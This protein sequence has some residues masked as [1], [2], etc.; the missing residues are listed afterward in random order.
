MKR[1]ADEVTG[2]DDR[3]G[4][5]VSTRPPV[6]W[7]LFACML[8]VVN[9]SMSAMVRPKW[10]EAKPYINGETTE[11]GSFR[12]VRNPATGAI[13]GTVQLAEGEHVDAAVEAA[14]AAFPGWR[15]RTPAERGR[16]LLDACH[17]VERELGELAATI[18][19]EVGK[20]RHEAF[21][22]ISG[23]LA[24]LRTFVA[25]V[26]EAD[27]NEDQTGKPGTGG[28]VR[29]IVRRVPVGPVAVIGPWN[30]P[31]FLTFNGVAPSLATGCTVVVK[32]PVEAPLALTAMLRILADR[33][34]P[35]V[36]NVVP[37]RGGV[38]GQRLA[39]HPRIRAIMFT[40]STEVG[41]SVARA[42]AGTVKKV[43]LELGGNDPAIVLESASVT[44]ALITELVAGSFAMTGQICFNIKRLYVHRSR[45]DEVVAAMRSALSYLVVG[46][47]VD[48]G[49]HIGPLATADGYRN[50]KRLLASA[51]AA[52]ANVEEL[53]VLSETVDLDAGQ[54]IR[55]T[56]VTGIPRDHEL[57]LEEQFA[58]IMPILP[59]DDD[60]DAIAEA[61]GTEFGLASSVWSDDLEHAERVARR[62][63]A[64]STFINAHRLGASVPLTPFGGVKQSGLGRTHGHYSIEHCTEEHAIVAFDDAAAQ[65]PGIDHWRAITEMAHNK[66]EQA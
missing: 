21:A 53:G 61:N 14:E 48:A 19:L 55:P 44:P 59:F 5:G 65:L 63:E 1:A 40:G 15:D 7:S 47:P 32:P 38:V 16:L 10:R 23:S 35:G 4:T 49:A 51:R 18:S 29:V 57:V 45:Y 43:A 41:R 22:D 36:L 60:A 56:I 9:E 62:I 11:V 46:D 2:V 20:V 31:A 52:G 30:T 33:L 27:A 3:H 66:E 58:P 42:A 28:A 12:H 34:P 17:A 37:G 6:T 39:E 25:L 64:G 24:L 54:Y 26:E 13:I 8:G 50:A